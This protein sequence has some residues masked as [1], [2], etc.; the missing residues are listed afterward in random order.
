MKTCRALSL[1]CCFLLS[2]GGTAAD[3]AGVWQGS[4]VRLTNSCQF[5]VAADINPL[6]PLT[7]TIDENEV[8]TVQAVDGS[9]AV[10]GQGSGETSSFLASAPVFGDYGPI[11]PYNCE[12]VLSSVGFLDRGTDKATV[13]LKI[14]FSKCRPAGS[15]SSP[16]NCAAIYSSESERIG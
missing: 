1:L 14:S 11:A 6:F 15:T 5:P 4:F 8:Y 16:R 9:R 7:V 13:T 3:F 10:G 2:C 12:S